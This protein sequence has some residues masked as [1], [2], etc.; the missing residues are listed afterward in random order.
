MKFKATPAIEQTSAKRGLPSERIS[1]VPPEVIARKG[2][3]S[4]TRRM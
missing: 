4:A 1:R 2:K 3:P